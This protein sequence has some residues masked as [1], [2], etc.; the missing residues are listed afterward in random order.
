M[1]SR[2][3]S[4]CPSEDRILRLPEVIFIT[5]RSASSIWRD[6]RNRRFPPRRK[7]GPG[8]VGWLYSEIM[9]WL[10]SRQACG[11]VVCANL[12]DDRPGS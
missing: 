2:F 6:E 5:K 10:E 7:L 9:A 8:A 12:T 1:S 4:S 3:F 11:P